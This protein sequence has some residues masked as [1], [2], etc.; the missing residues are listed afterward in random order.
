MSSDVRVGTREAPN[1]RVGHLVGIDHVITAFDAVPQLLQ[2]HQPRL[3]A[4][5]E[6]ASAAGLV[7]DC[8][9]GHVNVGRHGSAIR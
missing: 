6:P 2:L 8:Q 9:N 5:F 4:S 1:D 3:V 7:S